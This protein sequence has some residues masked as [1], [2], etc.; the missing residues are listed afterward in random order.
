MMQR[1][2]WLIF[3]LLCYPFFAAAETAVYFQNNTNS[4]FSVRTIQYGT[5][6][7]D[8]NEWSATT[9]SISAWQR[10]VEIMETNRNSG[11]HNGDDFYFDMTW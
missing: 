7:L 8:A 5:H 9:I 6:I 2:I 4:N 1:L 11:I 10:G 3:M